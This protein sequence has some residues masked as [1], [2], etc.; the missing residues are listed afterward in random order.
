M[1]GSE[2]V[3]INCDRGTPLDA[4]DVESVVD[5]QYVYYQR[6]PQTQ[7]NPP[8]SPISSPEYDN[9]PPT[10]EHVPLGYTTPPPSNKVLHKNYM[11]R[12]PRSFDGRS[13][14]PGSEL[15]CPICL[16]EVDSKST[17]NTCLHKFCFTC[18]LEWSKVKAVCPLCKGKFTRILYNFRSDNDYDKCILPPPPEP[19]QAASLQVFLHRR[20]RDVYTL[21]LRARPLSDITNRFRE[22]SPEWYRTN[23]AQTHRLVPWLNRE[24]NVVLDIS[25][26]Q[27]REEFLITQILEWVKLYNITSQEMRDQLLPYLSTSTEHFQHEFYQFARSPFD[28]PLYDRLVTYTNRRVTIEVVSSD[29]D[30]DD[31]TADAGVDGINNSVQFIEEI[32]NREYESPENLNRILAERRTVNPTLNLGVTNYPD[33]SGSKRN[34]PKSCSAERKVE[35]NMETSEERN[36]DVN[37]DPLRREGETE[38]GDE[39]H[40]KHRREM[41]RFGGISNRLVAVG[42]RR[43]TRKL[44]KYRRYQGATS[45][46]V[47]DESSIDLS[48]T[49]EEMMDEVPST[50][51]GHR[52]GLSRL[53]IPDSDSDNSD[54]EVVDVIKPKSR[55]TTNKA[56]VVIELGESDNDFDVPQSRANLKRSRKR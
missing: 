13:S 29:S 2:P 31:N 11:K 27:G 37:F 22:C 52:C 45:E 26:Q 49:R 35:R 51:S 42:N 7:L 1:E 9:C 21:D 41:D 3:S 28:L 24:L 43:K 6:S 20:R 33:R 46:D 23:E 53:V 25:G 50:S 10:P 16:G 19:Q 34:R 14:P 12:R 40:G 15:T 54:I 56:P 32:R 5:S 8:S 18:L 30:N 55:K 38:R 44:P 36:V 17:T 48:V 39:S 4:L 47:H